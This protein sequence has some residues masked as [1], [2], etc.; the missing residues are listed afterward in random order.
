M[1]YPQ[2][3]ARISLLGQIAHPR[4][5]TSEGETPQRLLMVPENLFK[6][7]GFKPEAVFSDTAA[8]EE[9]YR[10]LYHQPGEA[11]QAMRQT[12]DRLLARK[13]PARQMRALVPPPKE[14][15][16]PLEH[17]VQQLQDLEHRLITL[18]GATPGVPRGL[19]TREADEA[20]AETLLMPGD[21]SSLKGAPLDP[22][23]RS[24]VFGHSHHAV[25]TPLS[26]GG[27]YLNTGTWQSWEDEQ[28]RTHQDLTYVLI[29]DKHSGGGIELQFGHFKSA[30][31]WAVPDDR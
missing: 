13:A 5:L 27:L 12:V 10:K 20:A 7:D 28:G 29:H 23:I 8:V 4:A 21:R 15:T 18:P 6:P 11:R 14:P 17:D 16:R 9:V 30:G 2:P 24:I 31:G 26:R 3:F 19:L 25:K 22:R 1:T